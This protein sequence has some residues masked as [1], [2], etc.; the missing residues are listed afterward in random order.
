M[1]AI[2]ADTKNK[3]DLVVGDVTKPTAKGSNVLVEIHASS[4]NPHDWKYHEWFKTF[5]RSPLPLPRLMLGHDVSGVVVA[6]GNNVKGFEVGDEVFSMS[7]KTGAFA[8]FA[9]IDY[10][11]LA[12]KPKNISH[13]EAAT[14][15]MAGLTALQA[16]KICRI[17]PDSKVL[18]IGGS[19]GVGSLAVQIAKAEGAEVTAV[20]SGRNGDFVKG[21]GADTIIDYTKADFHDCGE[22][23]DI[24]FDT[25]GGESAKS[26][27]TILAKAGHFLSTTTSLKNIAEIVRSRSMGLVDSETVK[28]GTLLALPFAT[29][30]EYLSS[31]IEEGKLKPEVDKTFMLDQIIDAIDYSKLGRTRGKIAITI[32]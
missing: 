10:R 28:A 14:I 29:D 31:L 9:S 30:L 6:V 15:P 16:L 13:V 22:S 27:E 19:G 23:F 7:A 2:Y 32:K 8:E 25:I 26:C 5:Y 24:V 4:L 20:C 11:M 17:K 12:H 21:L 18:I 1:K 3:G